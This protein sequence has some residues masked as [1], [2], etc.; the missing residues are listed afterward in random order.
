[1]WAE[2]EGFDDDGVVPAGHVV[3]LRDG[4]RTVEPLFEKDSAGRIVRAP[5]DLSRDTDEAYLVL[6]GTGIRFRSSLAN[7][8][9]AMAG[10]A[11]PVD[12][13]GPQDE[14]PGLDQI[15]V[16]L[17]SRLAAGLH[18]LRVAVDARQTS[19]GCVAVK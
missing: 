2:S 8:I 14:F 1:M 4:V 19:V 3:R 7:V 11:L 13:A 15:S 5:V 16:R 9:V 10:S 12:Y 6:Y 17:P 18:C